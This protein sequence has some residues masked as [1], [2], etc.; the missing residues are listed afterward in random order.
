MLFARDLPREG[1]RICLIGLAIE[2]GSRVTN[3]VGARVLEIISIPPLMI[4]L[5]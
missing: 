4:S 3:E 5:G 2:A 1:R